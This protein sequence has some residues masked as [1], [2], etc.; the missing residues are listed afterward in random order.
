[1]YYH[2]LESFHRNDSNMLSNIGCD[3]EIREELASV[4]VNFTLHIWNSVKEMPSN[5]VQFK[6]H[7]F[8]KVTLIYIYVK[9]LSPYNVWANVCNKIANTLPYVEYARNTFWTR[10]GYADIRRHTLPYARGSLIVCVYM[11]TKR[12]VSRR[13]DHTLQIH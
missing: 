12:N 7:R 1:M 9:S 10:F 3:Q 2:L 6:L 8:C 11:Y 4:A 13:M 5:G